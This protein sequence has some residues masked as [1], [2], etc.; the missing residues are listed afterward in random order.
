MPQS[1]KFDIKTSKNQ[2]CVDHTYP[3]LASCRSQLH[4]L[5]SRTRGANT[6]SS[7]VP[8][9]DPRYSHLGNKSLC[10]RLR[11]AEN[12]VHTR[13]FSSLVRRQ[14]GELRLSSTHNLKSTDTMCLSSCLTVQ[15][16]LQHCSVTDRQTDGQKQSLNPA[17]AYVR[18]VKMLT[19][20]LVR[21]LLP[22]QYYVTNNRFGARVQ[23]LCRILSSKHPY[24]CKHTPTF[25]WFACICV[26][27]TNGFPCK[28]P[29]RFW[30]VNFKHPWAITQ[31][32][33]VEV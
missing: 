6:L 7:A 26:I 18:G 21:L 32:T 16:S 17:S 25:L 14:T 3:A 8:V 24:P 20:L 10:T 15:I 2:K 33:T 29:P 23:S 30:P 19:P 11:T 5:A 27:H 1:N 12:G 31:D 4:G 9:L 28:R 22:H 13:D